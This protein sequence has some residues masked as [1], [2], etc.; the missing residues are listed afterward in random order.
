MWARGY[1]DATVAWS[2]GTIWDNKIVEVWSKKVVCMKY[3]HGVLLYHA[4]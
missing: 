4:G 2:T 3:F 1:F